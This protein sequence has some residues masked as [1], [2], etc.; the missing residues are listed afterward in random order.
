MKKLYL[1]LVTAWLTNPVTAQDLNPN[2][3]GLSPHTRKY[4]YETGKEQP[5]GEIQR[6]GYIYKRLPDGRV[7]IASLAK[8]G[9]VSAAQ[10]ALDQIGAVVGTRAGNIWTILVPVDQVVAYT[11]IPGISYIQLDE[12][13]FPYMDA[14]RRT[15]RTDS[16]HMGY[17]LP[18]AFTGKDVV[19]GVIDFGFD[20]NHPTFFDTLGNEYRIKRSWELNTTGTPP[21]GFAYG[22]E[23]TDAASLQAQGTDNNVQTH[24][25]GVAGIAAGS[26]YGGT[27]ATRCR[28]VAYESEL[29]FVGVRR[30]LIAEQWRQGGFSDF[31]DGINYIFNYADA[32]EKPAVVNISWGSH[33]GPHDGSTLF[34]EACDS[35]SDAGKIIIMSAGNDGTDSIHLQKTFT[36]TDTVVHTFLKFIPTATTSPGNDYKRTWVDI[37]GEPGKAFC[38]SLSLYDNGVAGN[39]TDVLCT[40]DGIKDTFLISANGLDTC[41]IEFIGSPSEFNGKPRLTVVVHNKTDDDACVS[42]TGTDGLVHMWN[43]YYFYGYIDRYS[44]IFSKGGQSWATSGDNTHTVS[45]MGSA[46]SVLLVGAYASKTG[47]RDVNNFPRSY[48]GYVTVG[49]IAPFSSRGP[50]ADGRIKPDIAAPGLTLAT[51]VNS[52]DLAYTP[53]GSSNSN[54]IS[55]FT[56][57]VSGKKYYF[58][59]FIGTSAS[60]PVASGIVALM[61]QANPRLTP[62][63]VIGIIK[64]T[65]ITDANTGTIPATGN[66]TWGHGKI[67]AYAA[68]KRAAQQ[69]GVY[70]FSGEKLDCVLYPNPAS[71]FFTIEYTGHRAEQLQ[72][73]IQDITGRVVTGT[74]WQV[75]P[76]MNRE[77]VDVSSLPAGTYIARI[78]SKSGSVHIKM[79]VE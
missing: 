12:P 69:N 58:G 46:G 17:D 16:V 43:E 61:L 24:G 66:N 27:T 3:P 48:S 55:E 74:S 50:M 31:V 33:S 56:H 10:E 57:P 38:A 35:L 60:A 64:E 34:N 59:E 5:A 23:L 42:V 11:R 36:A 62:E 49:N 63:E 51:A 70:T 29:V 30:E 26:G 47:Y 53:T 13:V 65:A 44:S 1:L 9:N 20:Y 19:M 54:V 18:Q 8:I 39:H 68:V 77:Q 15:T 40:V 28:G 45:D 78:A 72:L 67:N 52:H 71:G 6:E 22:H 32:V 79:S 4:L 7:T 75:H 37:W 41:F 21:A 76:G 14:A 25:T 73:I 2:T